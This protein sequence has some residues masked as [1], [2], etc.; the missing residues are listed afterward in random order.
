MT[1]K[2][3]EAKIG[4]GECSSIFIGEFQFIIYVD[5]NMNGG[6]KVYIQVHH[7]SDFADVI[8]RE[9]QY[10]TT[11][12]LEKDIRK[13]LKQLSKRINKALDENDR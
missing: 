1:A 9:K 7:D 12:L 5:Y 11:E 6:E 10:S 4:F 3:L 13:Q 2:E 8:D